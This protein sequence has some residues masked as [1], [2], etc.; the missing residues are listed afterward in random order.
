M[1]LAE[2]EQRVFALQQ[3]LKGR[4]KYLRWLLVSS[5]RGLHLLKVEAITWIEAQGNYVRVHHDTGSHLLRETIGELESHLNPI[6]FLRIH[7]SAIAQIG[8]I[9]ELLPWQH[10]E[11]RV[12]LENGTQLT[13]TRTYRANLQRAIGI[14]RIVN[15]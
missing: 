2:R 1:D 13:L 3:E 12:I 5:G 11:Y 8:R 4:P 7:R 15:S 14:P 6:N 10:G 9:K